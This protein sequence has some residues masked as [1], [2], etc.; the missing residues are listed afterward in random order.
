LTQSDSGKQIR[1]GVH[2]MLTI[3][4]NSKLADSGY[5]WVLLSS[6]APQLKLKHKGSESDGPTTSPN[7]DPILGRPEIQIFTFTAARMGTGRLSAEYRGISGPA[8]GKFDVT[9]TVAP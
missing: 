9:V 1:L 8:A 6:G 5:G 3:R 2:E 4:L 7:G